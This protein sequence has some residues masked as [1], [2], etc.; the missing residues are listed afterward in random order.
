M[1]RIIP[2]WLSP[3]ADSIAAAAPRQG[4]S[5]WADAVHLMWSI[6]VFVTPAFS[7]G[8]TLRWL[9]LTLASYP[10]F[11]LLYALTLLAPRRRAYLY[12]LGLVALSMVLLPWY[13]SGISYFI[14]GCVMLRNQRLPKLGGYLVQLLLLNAAFVGLAWWVGYSW[15]SLVW[16]PAMTLV[17]GVII[18]VERTS[19]ENSAALK[20]SHEEVRKL[21]ASAERERIGRDLHDLLGHTLSLITLKLELSRKLFDRDHEAARREIIEAERV[22]RHALTEVR[23]AVTGIRATDLAV[24]LASARLLLES[25]QVFL[26]YDAPPALPAPVGQGLALILREA[27]TNI[28]RHARASR[29][30]ISYACAGDAVELSVVD[31]GA[32]GIAADGNGLS[33][34]RERVGAL[35]GTLRVESPQGRG[36]RLTVRIPVKWLP[37]LEPAAG[38]A[39]A[40]AAAT[41]AAPARLRAV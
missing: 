4:K 38:Q 35:G 22:A 7:G 20:L 15:Q 3:A 25:S 1:S 13:P 28:A 2:A 27:V 23:S 32:G 39:A 33:G 9:L 24:E 29:A 14:F 10:L 41:P 21:A 6:W 36:T 31:N 5:P 34:M 19:Q 8:Y 40:T 18:S 37:V 11:L 17:I 26:H 12:A 30:Q 16:I